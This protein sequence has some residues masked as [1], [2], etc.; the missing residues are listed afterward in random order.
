MTELAQAFSEAGHAMRG[1]AAALTP[2]IRLAIQRYER[3]LTVSRAVVSRHC[4]SW[5]ISRPF[6]RRLTG[7]LPDSFVLYVARMI[8]R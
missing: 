4:S 3:R 6:A 2:E 1:L 8:K 7:R 5:G